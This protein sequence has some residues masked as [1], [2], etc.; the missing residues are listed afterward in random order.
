MRL[1]T[2]TLLPILTLVT[3]TFCKAL[4]SLDTNS[5]PL[6]A[7]PTNI[8][9]YTDDPLEELK[10]RIRSRASSHRTLFNSLPQLNKTI[11]EKRLLLRQYREKLREMNELDESMDNQQT[12]HKRDL[13]SYNS[14]GMS[15]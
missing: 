13:H 5:V 6:V 3:N 10:E 15:H 8:P 2:W 1:S 9:E 7:P 14:A 12:I 11:E 4:H